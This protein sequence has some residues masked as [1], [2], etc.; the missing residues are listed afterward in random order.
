MKL[1]IS[2]GTGGALQAPEDVWTLPSISLYSAH[3][4]DF[5]SAATF[6]E[7]PG[8][9][10]LCQER[11]ATLPVLTNAVFFHESNEICFCEEQGRTGFPIHHLHRGGL[12]A[13]PLLIQRDNLKGRRISL[14]VLPGLFTQDKGSE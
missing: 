12:K 9:N 10:S 3:L 5:L 1:L 6:G 13:R 14:K 7:F 2:L 8:E 11:E 4:S